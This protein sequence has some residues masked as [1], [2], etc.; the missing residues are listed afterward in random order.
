MSTITLFTIVPPIL[1]NATKVADI[2]SISI[3]VFAQYNKA[4]E[5]PAPMK[6]ITEN[7]SY[8]K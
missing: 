2:I 6:H 5:D 8:Y 4:Q 1:D 3:S 7:P